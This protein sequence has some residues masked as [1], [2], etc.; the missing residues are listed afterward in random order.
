MGRF[1]G[2][3]VERIWVGVSFFLEIRTFYICQE[4]TFVVREKK[5]RMQMPF[6]ENLSSYM[7]LVSAMPASPNLKLPRMSLGPTPKS[8]ETYPAAGE[9]SLL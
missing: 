4:D 9:R 6:D 3:Q 5:E 1:R 2:I 8:H 7:V